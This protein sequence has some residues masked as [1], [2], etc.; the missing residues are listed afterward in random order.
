M[1]PN[2]IYERLKGKNILVTGGTGMIGRQVC[3]LLLENTNAYV[4]S[5]SLDRFQL[6]DRVNYLYGD[7][8]D[9]KGF[10][11]ILKKNYINCV[12]HCAGIKGSPKVTKERPASFFVPLLQMNTNVLEASRMYGIKDLIYTS[13]IGA[14]G[15]I[16]EDGSYGVSPFREESNFSTGN[17]ID[18]FPGWAKRMAELQIK[19]YKIEYGLNYSTVRLGNVY[20]EGDNF[21][22]DNAM[23]IPSLMSKVYSWRK[24]EDTTLVEIFGDGKSIRDFCYSRD[25]AEGIILA[26]HHGTFGSLDGGEVGG[27]YN[28]GGGVEYDIDTVIKTLKKIVHFTH[29]Y[30][31]ESSTYLKRVLDISLARKNLGFNPET[32][33]EEGLKKTWDWFKKNPQEYLK[34]KNYFRKEK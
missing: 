30:T 3:D 10:Y 34:R 12:F 16:S 6:N 19:S 14:Y 31:M 5:V 1:I 4:V 29:G 27:F 2:E 9:F 13:S 21:D 28:L 18:S 25:I 7:L 20:G 17:P 24:A 8:S 32:S 23:F 11:D 26:L 22:S 15:F 33:L